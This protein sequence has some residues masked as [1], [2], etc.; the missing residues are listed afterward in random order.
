MK[1]TVVILFICFSSASCYIM[2]DLKYRLH[3]PGYHT[4]AEVLRYAEPL[5]VD[6]RIYRLNDFNVYKKSPYR[7]LGSAV[8]DLLIFN[9]DGKL[10]LFEEAISRNLDSLA[11][12]TIHQIEGLPISDRGLNDLLDDTYSIQHDSLH[13][14]STPAKPVF[15]IKFAKHTGKLNNTNVPILVHLLRNRTDVQFL[16][17][18]MDYTVL[19]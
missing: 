10:T 6:D 18:N 7:Y 2:R 12:L 3:N 19:E 16:L 5:N 4:D 1:I 11:Q 17:L 15:V 13:I 8:P 9:S 14:S